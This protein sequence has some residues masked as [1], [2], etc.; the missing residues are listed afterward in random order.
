VENTEKGVE[1]LR[2]A[3][4]YQK[5]S[6]TKMCVLALIVVLIIAVAMIVLFII[7]KK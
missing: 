3:N 1:E 4:E 7:L 5:K 6:R 2:T